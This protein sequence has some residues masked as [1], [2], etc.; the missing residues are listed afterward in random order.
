MEPKVESEESPGGQPL[1]LF[2]PGERKY[3]LY[4]AALAATEPLRVQ[5]DYKAKQSLK[6]LEYWW[7]K[8]KGALASGKGICDVDTVDPGNH[9][10]RLRS[11]C[12]DHVRA[13]SGVIK[14]LGMT[15]AEF[16]ALSRKVAKDPDLRAR[17]MQQAYCYRVAAELDKS[18]I[19]EQIPD[20]RPATYSQAQG[21]AQG[22]APAPAP[23]YRGRPLSTETFAVLSARVERLRGQLERKLMAELGIP[24][25][26]EGICGPTYLPMLAPSVRNLCVSFP[27]LA[28]DLIE[29]EGVTAAEFNAMLAAAGKNPW[30]RWRLAQKLK[31]YGVS[32]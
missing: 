16:N 12:K 23:V 11:A 19:G 30:L 29:G 13:M 8:R 3:E 9:N 24:S 18:A 26:P 14:A 17:V 32:R 20:R 4:A 25:L 6:P 10:P 5:R 28:T 27:K 22:T 31:K 21:A 7:L 1:S 2:G 15:V